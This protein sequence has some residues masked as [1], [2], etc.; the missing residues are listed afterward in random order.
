VWYLPTSLVLDPDAGRYQYPFSGSCGDGIIYIRPFP[1]LSDQDKFTK[2]LERKRL[3]NVMKISDTDR[4]QESDEQPSA[5]YTL[6][7][8]NNPLSSPGHCWARL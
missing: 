4:R 8:T 6:Y 5:L 2:M 3:A 1:H 7:S